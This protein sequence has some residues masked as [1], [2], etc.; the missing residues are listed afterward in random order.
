MCNFLERLSW[1]QFSPLSQRLQNRGV[2][3]QE[4]IDC[5]HALDGGGGDDSGWLS[6]SVDVPVILIVI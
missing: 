2:A 4:G 1:H 6:E 5:K 3:H